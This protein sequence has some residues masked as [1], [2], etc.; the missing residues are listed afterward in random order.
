VGVVVEVGLGVGW[1]VVSGGRVVDQGVVEGVFVGAIAGVGVGGVRRVFLVVLEAAFGAHVRDCFGERRV[2][3][4]SRVGD[5]CV[6]H[7]SDLPW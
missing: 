7:V 4:V 6:N 1:V 5:F 2:K 3:G